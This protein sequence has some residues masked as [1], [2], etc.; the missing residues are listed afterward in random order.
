MT[1]LSRKR[2]L[3]VD[4]EPSILEVIG[5]YLEAES[6]AVTY[7]D[8]GTEGLRRFHSAEFDLVVSDRNMPGMSGEEL[9]EAIK[10]HTPAM[11]FIL[12]SGH[13]FDHAPEAHY[14]SFLPKPFSRKQLLAALDAALAAKGAA[15]G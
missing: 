1:N 11:P 9:A 14:D 13:A 12:I 7:A 2:V 3:L 4:D 8:S 10:T 5:L 15:E 6:Y